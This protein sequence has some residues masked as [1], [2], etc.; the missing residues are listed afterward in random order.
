MEL[1]AQ[2]NGH[3]GSCLG[4]VKVLVAALGIAALWFVVVV[5]SAPAGSLKDAKAC[6]VA[7]KMSAKKAGL[8]KR[9]ANSAARAACSKATLPGPQG[10]IG[11]AG[12]A[13][14][15]GANGEPGPRGI[16]GATGAE[17]AEG[18]TGTTG[19][20]GPTGPEG[21]IGPHGATGE[22]GA[23]GDDGIVGPTGATGADGATGPEGPTGPRGDVGATG[24][25]G[26]T[27]E[28]GPPATGLF[29]AVDSS[30]AIVEARSSGVTDSSRPEN[31]NYLVTFDQDVSNCIYIA[32]QESL[33][34]QTSP[35]DT[36]IGFAEAVPV[37]GNNN[38]VRVFIYDKGGSLGFNRS[39][40]LAVVC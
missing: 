18:A 38:Q 1:A 23:T 17:G 16:R 25:T 12:E 11:P 26:A 37:T 30:G 20:E 32:N 9:K 21:P 14:T 13:G 27:G 24:V 35:S 8:S 6:R 22:T 28:Q 15:A 3:M 7:M 4:A 5:E 19:A 29:A 31:G 10:P 39:F 33:T 34:A 36:R 40:E 2:R